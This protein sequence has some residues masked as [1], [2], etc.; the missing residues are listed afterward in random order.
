MARPPRLT[1]SGALHHVTAR[2][3][4]RSTIFRAARDY[5]VFLA[6][7]AEAGAVA[8]WHCLAYCLMP[9]HYHLLV[10]STDDVGLSRGMQLLNGTYAARYNAAH[11]RVGHVF[12]GRFHDEL[13]QRDGH[14]LEAARYIALNPVRANLVPSPESWEWSSHA[15]MLGL[16]RHDHWLRT[17]DLL[18]L[19]GDDLA[20]ARERYRTFV[21]AGA[22][23]E[24][25]PLGAL[26]DRRGSSGLVVAHKEYAYTQAEIAAYLAVS[27]PTV[28]RLLRRAAPPE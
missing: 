13:I 1:F 25:P 27:Q 4:G 23:R 3:V 18:K 19:F 6:T 14:L 21:G 11:E 24:R 5:T 20:V 2:G 28:S 7:L 22:V 17:A 10:R 12:Q 15:A 26:I 16:R 8:R 9:N